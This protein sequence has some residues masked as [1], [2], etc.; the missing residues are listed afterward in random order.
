MTKSWGIRFFL[1]AGSFCK[2]AKL[3]DFFWKAGCYCILKAGSFCKV[4]KLPDFFWKAGCYC[5]LKAG[6]FCKVA[7][8]QDFFK[9]K[10][11]VVSF[12][13]LGHFASCVFF[14]EKHGG[15]MKAESRSCYIKAEICYF[16]K[17]KS[18]MQDDTPF[19]KKHEDQKQRSIYKTK[20]HWKTKATILV[21]ET[22]APTKT[23]A[24]APL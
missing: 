5:I 20:C 22:C 3:P 17:N 19:W 7:K 13:K 1:K 8:L 21:T 2:V 18:N 10:Q 4:A 23:S 15:S 16:F 11:G 12:W 9:K 24:S 6:S 14:L